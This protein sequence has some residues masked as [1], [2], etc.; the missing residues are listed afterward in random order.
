MAALADIFGRRSVLFTAICFFTVGSV[1]CCIA[2]DLAVMLAGRTLQG[3]GGGGI[4][5]LNMIILS[6]LVPLRARPK[7]ICIQQLAVALGLNIA[8]IIGGALIEVTTWR[9]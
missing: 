1:L 8:P 4:F 3:V 7:Y 5:S 6:D 9:W 2:K